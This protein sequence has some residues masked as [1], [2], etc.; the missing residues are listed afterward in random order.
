MSALEQ[1]AD[2]AV[3]ALGMP[4]DDRGRF[5][6]ER[7]IDVHADGFDSLL[8]EEPSQAVHNVLGATNRKGRD[9]DAPTV[10]LLLFDE[11]LEIDFE[12]HS[13][14]MQAVSVRRL[15]HEVVDIRHLAR[16]LEDRHLAATVIARKAHAHDFIAVSQRQ[17]DHGRTENVPRVAEHELDV[18]AQRHRLAIVDAAKA[19]LHHLGVFLG[20]DRLDA[21]GAALAPLVE[22]PRVGLLQVARVA[23]HDRREVRGR[24]STPDLAAVPVP[25]EH[26]QR[27]R[28]VDVRVREDAVIDTRRVEG[29]V[30]VRRVRVPSPPLNEAAVE[31]D[32]L[33]LPFDEVLGSCDGSDG[34]IKPQA[35]ATHFSTLTL[36]ETIVIGAVSRLSS[37]SV[38]LQHEVTR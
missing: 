38:K 27:P 16:I 8:R 10:A 30:A 24:V 1:L 29:Q 7:R 18:V 6:R 3:E 2:F 35:T 9:Q 23:K 34:A 11:P 36:R 31:E 37:A 33:P 17:D 4:R 26:G 14:G 21:R 28:V 20:V 15:G 25:D 13:V 5:A 19:R 32:S 12:R 22:V